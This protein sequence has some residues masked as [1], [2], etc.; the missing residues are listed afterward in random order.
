MATEGLKATWEQ[1]GTALGAWITL[2]EPLAVQ[3]ACAI[4]YDYVCIDMQHG[5]A[6]Y[7]DVLP[8][9]Q[10][11]A[12]SASTPLVRVPWNEPGIIGRVLDAGALGVIIPMVNSPEEARQAVAACRYPPEGTRSFGPVGAATTYGGAYV[13]RANRDV[14]CIPMIETRDAVER[15]DEILA[16][17]G[18]DAVYVG[19]ADLSFSLGMPPALDTTGDPFDS[20]VRRI[21]EA[22]QRAGVVPG[23]HATAALADTRRSSG[24]RMITVGSDLGGLGTGLR[25]DLATASSSTSASSGGEAATTS[26]AVARDVT[27]KTPYGA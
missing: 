22:C 18:I 9:L 26:G 27:P 11:A 10:A 19:P 2:R 15:I 3:M 4:G 5:L 8:L 16:V 24:F 12:R 13:G 25:Q 17:P 23:V 21:I 20:A 14:A 7:R 1:G 6:D